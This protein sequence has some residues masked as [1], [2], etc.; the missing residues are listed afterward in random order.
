VNEG[1]CDHKPAKTRHRQ[2]SVCLSASPFSMYVCM[3]VYVCTYLQFPHAAAAHDEHGVVLNALRDLQ[4][5]HPVEG[6]DVDG[7]P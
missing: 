3:C 5:D 7:A 1:K 2:R 6:E 4:F